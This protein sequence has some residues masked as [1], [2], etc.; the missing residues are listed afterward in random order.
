[1]IDPLNITNYSRTRAELEEFILNAAAFAGKNARQQA[2]KM[3]RILFHDAPVGSP[4][5]K[6]RSWGS[7]NAVAAILTREKI[8]KYSLLSQLYFDLA[9]SDIDLATCSVD[10][11]VSY[12]GI[13]PKTARFFVLHSR[14]AQELVVL[15][16][17]I[18]KEMRS[19]GFTVPSYTPSGKKYLELEGQYIEHLKGRGIDDFARHDLDTWKKYS[20]ARASS[21]V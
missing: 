8:G 4:F 14:R 3:H 6:I 7:R 5:E 15:D 10:E 11:L 9:H 17:H 13:G 16:T 21:A 18:L 19:L 1:V 12:R 20:L 2:V